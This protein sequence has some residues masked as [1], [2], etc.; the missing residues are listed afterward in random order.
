MTIAA[1]T[2][3]LPTHSS[4]PNVIE[5][6]ATHP[7]RY[8]VG[9]QDKND[10]VQR[11]LFRDQC[12]VSCE[13]PF[14]LRNFISIVRSSGFYFFQYSRRFGEALKAVHQFCLAKPDHFFGLCVGKFRRR[15]LSADTPCRVRQYD[16]CQDDCAHRNLPR[17]MVP[18]AAGAGPVAKQSTS[19]KI[20]AYSPNRWTQCA[21]KVAIAFRGQPDIG[22]LV[23]WFGD[24]GSVQSHEC[25]SQAER[26]VQ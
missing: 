13:H 16:G 22:R 1:M 18:A 17:W 11:L 4:I 7:V 21:R 2:N 26:G 15:H 5:G 6:D 24:G 20:P 25:W 3:P 23:D 14:T 9:V 8:L 12:C 19:R 10:G